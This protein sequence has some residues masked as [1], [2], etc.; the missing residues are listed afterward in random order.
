MRVLLV[1]KCFYYK[2][3]AE[4]FLFEVA[5]VLRENGHEVAF[6]SNNDKNNE[7]SEWSKYFIDAPDFKNPSPLVKLKALYNIPYNRHAKK[8]F[9]QLLDDFR[10]DVVH[11]FNIMTQISPSIIVAARKKNIPVVLSHLDYK[12]ICPSYML[13]YNGHIC[14]DCKDGCYMHCIKNRCAH[15]SMAYSIA[16]TIE[17]YVH[18]W[19]RIYEKNVTLHLFSCDFMAEKTEEFWGRKINKGKLLNP[20]KV[21]EK[22]TDNDDLEFGLY[23]GRLSEEKGVDVLLRAL[24]FEKSVRFVIVGNGPDEDKLKQMASELGISNVEFVGPKWGKELDE[25]LSR[26]KYVVVPSV[27]QE[28][29][30]Y[31]ILQAFA[32]CKPVIGSKRGGIPEMVTEDRGLLYEADDYKMLAELM[33]K[34]DS[35]PALCRKMGLAARNFIDATFTDREFYKALED[36]YKRAIK[37]NLNK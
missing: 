23:F 28:N 26:A 35:S 19:M 8:V 34:L 25:Y 2:G 24:S 30:P 31:V 29:Y 33:N 37:L 4:M 13:Y 11:C 18:K 12:H 16:S 3:G 14:D 5:R 27:W 36:N 22:P 7:E 32:A 21:P 1:H 15:G 10:P 20:L 6:F 9:S 17:A